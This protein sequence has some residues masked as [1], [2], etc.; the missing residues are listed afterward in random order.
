MLH[1]KVILLLVFPFYCSFL[2][3]QPSDNLHKLRDGLKNEWLKKEK[4]E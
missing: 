2:L 4:T 1:N 3:S